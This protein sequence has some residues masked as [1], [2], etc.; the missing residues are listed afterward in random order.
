M[1]TPPAD[2]VDVFSGLFNGLFDGIYDGDNN[3]VSAIIFGTATLNPTPAIPEPGTVS[4][5]GL[6]LVGLVLASRRRRS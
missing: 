6:G 1:N 3:P 4:L 5:L 2:G